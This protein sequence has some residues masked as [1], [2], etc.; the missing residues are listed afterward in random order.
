MAKRWAINDNKPSRAETYEWRHPNNEMQH[1]K[2]TTTP[3]DLNVGPEKIT[4][5]PTLS[6]KKTGIQ[7]GYEDWTVASQPDSTWYVFGT[8]IQEDD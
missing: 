8:I 4:L 6:P 3:T 2:E 5:K 1:T 7:S